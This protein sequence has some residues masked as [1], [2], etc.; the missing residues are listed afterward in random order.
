MPPPDEANSSMPS[1]SLA[2]KREDTIC[3]PPL[4]D[5]AV[6][7]LEEF[8]GI[9]SSYVSSKTSSLNSSCR[10]RLAEGGAA[11][12]LFLEG[13]EPYDAVEAE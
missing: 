10:N 4:A 13:A 5:G 1:W 11:P 7:A 12:P 3:L 6:A 8:D 9:M 2:E